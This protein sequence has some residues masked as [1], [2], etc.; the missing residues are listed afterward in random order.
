MWLVPT[1]YC[2]LLQAGSISND[3]FGAVFAMAAV[4]FAL[5]ARQEKKD[6][7]PVARNFGC[8]ADDRRKGIQHSAA[9]AL[10]PGCVAR[11]AFAVAPPTCFGPDSCHGSVRFA[12]SNGRVEL[13]I[14]WRL[15]RGGGGTVGHS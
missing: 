8:G 12:F 13:A 1:G 9:F 5:R 11:V 14:L 2:F 15:D 10:G 3:L 6:G 4:D 7:R